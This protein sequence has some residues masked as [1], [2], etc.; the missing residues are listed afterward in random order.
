MAGNNRH[1]RATPRAVA[2]A[3]VTGVVA[4]GDRSTN[5]TPKRHFVNRV[6]HRAKR[7]VQYIGSAMNG[8]IVEMPITRAHGAAH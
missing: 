6:M 1:T 5:I 4:T 8:G 7:A 3:P 2:D